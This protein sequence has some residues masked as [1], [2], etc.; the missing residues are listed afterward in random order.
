MNFMSLEKINRKENPIQYMK[1][2]IWDFNKRDHL[3][4]LKIPIKGSS[5]IGI[6]L[7]CI[8]R[9]SREGDW[10]LDPFCGSGTTLLACS[11]LKRKG[12]AIEINPKIASIAK[13]NLEIGKTIPSINK[14]ISYQ[15]I[16]KG[17]SL[18]FMNEFLKPNSIDMVFAHPPYW[19]LIKYSEQYSFIKNDLSNEKTLAEFLIKIEVMFQGIKR[20]LKKDCFLCILIGDV[21]T[22][23]GKSIPL[24]YYLTKIALD[25]N[26][27]YHS[28]IIKVTHNATSR[29]N[30]IDYWEN[31]SIKE[32]I[33][34]CIHD[35]LLIFQNRKE[36]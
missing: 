28:K 10:I 11:Y 5:P 31:R 1:Y 7:Q 24:D 35:Y 15:K 33:F 3:D 32:N 14:W 19:N 16:I 18:F 2:S 9:F 20:V 26:F 6:P 22:H 36:G 23:S 30:K 4:I 25:N 12:I 27:E 29:K 17:D 21:F 8:L 34:I 13:E